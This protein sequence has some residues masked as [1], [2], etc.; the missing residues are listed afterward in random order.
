M[1]ARAAFAK[2]QDDRRRIEP[3]ESFKTARAHSLRC[4]ALRCDELLRCAALRR[5]A[6]RCDELRCAA[7]GIARGAVPTA[8]PD[9]RAM[10]RPAGPVAQG[11]PCRACVRSQGAVWHTVQVQC[12]SAVVAALMQQYCFGTECL[13]VCVCVCVCVCGCVCVCVSVCVCVWSEIDRPD[14]TRLRS[15]ERC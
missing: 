6:L 14:P 3:S 2:L 10:A 4:A 13:Q 12:P 5:A 1:L 11:P 8:G 15:R 9:A 7:A